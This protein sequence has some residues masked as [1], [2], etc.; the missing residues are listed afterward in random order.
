MYHPDRIAARHDLLLQ[1]PGLRRLY[2]HGLLLYD[3][4]ATQILT[5][6]IKLTRDED[7]GTPIRPFTA[8]ESRFIAITRL[9]II[10]DA[11]YFLR[12]FV[13]IDEE[14][15]GIR[16]LYPLWKS[17]AFV[18]D[19]LGWL[20]QKRR[21]ERSPDGLLLN[22][23]KVRQ[24]GICLDPDTRVLTKD[25]RWVRIDDLRAGDRVVSV[26]E[27]VPGGRGSGRKMREAVVEVKREVIEPAFKLT[28]EDGRTVIATGP[29]RFL[30]L[31]RG[32]TDTTWRSVSAMRPGDYIRYVA[33]PW[34]ASTLDDGWFGGL[35]DG[36]GSFR[37]RPEGGAE[38]TLTQV[39]GPVYQ[40]AA[41]HVRARGWAFRESVDRRGPGTSSKFGTQP[42]HRIH[43]GRMNE[44][45]EI[46]GRTRP[47]RFVDQAWWQGKDLPG[48]KS[49]VAWVKLVSIEPVGTRRMIDIQ[50]STKT[51]IAEGLVSHNST[52]SMGLVAHRILTQSFI[53]AIAGS[54]TE[55]QA[56]YLFRMVERI[57]DH[58]PFF[59]KPERAVPYA[60]GREL[61][62]DT[63]SSIKTA[64]GKTTRG[65]LQAE[66]GRKGN[67][68]RG[69]TNSVVGISELAT[70]DNPEQLDSSLLPG[71]PVNPSTLVLFESTAELAGDWWH[72]H[73]QA[74]EEGN[75]RFANIFIT[76]P[77]KYEL[78]APADW[79]PDPFTL[80][81]C[82]EIERDSAAWCGTTLVPTRDNM[83]WYEQ[84]RAWYASKNQLLQ[85]LK[86]YPSNPRECFQYAG[87]SVFS[88]EEIEQINRAARP[89]IDVWRVDPA[90]E[91]A[92]LKRLPPEDPKQQ[93]Q[94]Q[95]DRR[96]I[97]PPLSPKVPGR[98][99][100]AQIAPQGYGF[101]RLTK[102]EIQ[103]LPSLRQ[104]VLAIYEYPRLK[105]RRRY[106]LGVDVGDGLQQD[107]SVVSV[108]REPTIEEPAEE[109]AQFVSNVVKPSQLAFIVDAIGHFYCD[110]DGVEACAAIELNNHGITVQDLL[111]LHLGYTNFYV[112]EV[113]DAADAS[114]RFT[115]RIGWQTTPR[116]RPI[117]IEKFHDAVTTFDPI[118][119]EQVHSDGQIHPIPDF[120]LNSIVTRTELGFFVTEGLMG[121]AEHAKGQHDDC[122]F[123]SAIGYYV[124]Y[125]LSGGEAEPLAERRRRRAQ[126][127][128]YAEQTPL[129]ARYDWR[130][131]A[132][133]AAAAQQ[134]DDDDG[135]DHGI[136]GED[137]PFFDPRRYG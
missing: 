89:L 42:V 85:F 72:R 95:V 51:F 75:G 23:L 93:D 3:D 57:Y 53:R 104:T 9:R 43:L 80:A 67:I 111:Q 24:V 125:R 41:Q 15:H 4:P 130:N 131:S 100:E 133:S 61:H 30:T 38:L 63:K 109:V 122:I 34:D 135:D 76:W 55:E 6:R 74:T 71:I 25:L 36:E 102:H 18:L 7:T 83:Y 49:G 105:G 98:A 39:D 128:A 70:W 134:G 77:V 90:R 37:P 46:L 31:K 17:Q 88:W 73:W 20:E 103:E 107:Y 65:A 22:V 28:F 129:G 84:T 44:L 54:D 26:D 97:V 106:V 5:E 94:Q 82:A 1:N 96:R 45:F 78:P 81:V 14:G 119:L 110:E 64:W 115:K 60:A 113:V 136:D 50:T 56:R 16:P 120:R 19:R 58:L 13:K 29:H 47:T 121:E 8:E 68:E 87:R 12:N 132:A 101:R 91:I 124:A 92:E 127:R 48:K 79:T 117:L 69:R 27:N 33:T 2:P 11:P 40:R 108:V 86:E 62:F 123:G 118:S 137:E 21:H 10:F 52:L 126:A 99:A 114:G 59:L 116:T 35:L 32:A 112:W 66:G